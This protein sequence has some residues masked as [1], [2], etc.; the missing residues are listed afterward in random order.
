MTEYNSFKIFFDPAFR[1]E[2]KNNPK[3]V[4]KKIGLTLSD[5]INIIIH[6]NTNQ[7]FHF[8]LNHKGLVNPFEAKSEIIDT[9][10]KK[11]DKDPDFRKH[12]IKNPLTA[13]SDFFKTLPENINI[14]IHENSKNTI[15]FVLPVITMPE[16][17]ELTDTDLEAVA[18]GKGG[19]GGAFF[20]NLFNG[21][22]SFLGTGVELGKG[23]F[24][25]NDSIPEL[26]K[27]MIN[28]PKDFFKQFF[29]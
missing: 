13:V 19:G 3:S 29:Y 11:A 15:H 16:S 5:D 14:H 23:M 7:D 24:V 28:N 12:L 4:I 10:R 8:T 27:E 1:S 22:K 9:I 2:L 18:G 21:T 17:D 25:G 6:E 26:T 20:K